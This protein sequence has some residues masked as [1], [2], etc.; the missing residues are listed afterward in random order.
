MADAVSTSNVWPNYSSQ[1]RVGSSGS[2]PG[3]L[4]KDEFLKILVAQIRSQNPLEPMGDTEFI[5]QMAQFSALEQMMN[6]ADAMNRLSGSLGLWSSM[7]G[8]TIGWYDVK[9][10][11]TVEVFTGIVDAIV[12]RNGKLYAVSG[13]REVP[14]E[15]IVSVGVADP[16]PPDEEGSGEG[17]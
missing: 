14:V 1:N 12:V 5:A 8:K 9:D 17:S 13:N 7:I 15:D 2:T 3:S 10:D 16:V 4:G 11:D 6:I